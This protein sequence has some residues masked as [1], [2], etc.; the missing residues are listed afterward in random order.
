M[1]FFST[2][3]IALGIN[4]FGLLSNYVVNPDN[5]EPTAWTDGAVYFSEEIFPN[6]KKLFQVYLAIYILIAAL[7]LK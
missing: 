7:S 6:I 2:S 1:V 4:L 3:A 5:L